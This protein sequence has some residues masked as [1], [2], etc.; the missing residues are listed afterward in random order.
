MD[1]LG[2]LEKGMSIK[3]GQSSS[4]EVLDASGMTIKVQWLPVIDTLLIAFIAI[5]IG[6]IIIVTFR[7]K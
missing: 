3:I 2:S 7:R 5:V 6:S 4:S 1:D